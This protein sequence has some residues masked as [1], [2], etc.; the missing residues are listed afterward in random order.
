MLVYL[1]GPRDLYRQTPGGCGIWG[2]LEFT[3]DPEHGRGASWLVVHNEPWEAFLSEA[4]RERR[5]LFV[6]EPPTIRKYPPRY[7]NQFGAA[8]SPPDLKRYAGKHIRAQP[9]LNW[10]FGLDGA[11]IGQKPGPLCYDDLAA[12]RFDDKRHA[13]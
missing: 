1:I 6:T 11:A 10:M 2:D 13:V 9:C 7:T 5:L 8:F 12:I 3:S 4:P